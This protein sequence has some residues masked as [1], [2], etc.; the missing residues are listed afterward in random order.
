MARDRIITSRVC[1]GR[2]IGVATDRVL[3]KI[4]NRS[5]FESS[6]GVASGKGPLAGTMKNQSIKPLFGL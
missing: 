4:T 2:S 1:F 5:G 3:M 6:T